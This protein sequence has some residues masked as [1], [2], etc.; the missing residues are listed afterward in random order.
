MMSEHLDKFGHWFGGS[1]GALVY[2]AIVWALVLL[3]WFFLWS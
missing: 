1:T 2:F 3:R